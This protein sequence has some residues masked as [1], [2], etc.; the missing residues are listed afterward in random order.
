[1]QILSE[2]TPAHP[3]SNAI[4]GMTL[5][6]STRW[7]STRRSR[8]DGWLDATVES[9]GGV[10]L[11]ARIRALD[12]LGGAVFDLV[13]DADGGVPNPVL[14]QCVRTGSVTIPRTPH[15]LTTTKDG[16]TDSRTVLALRDLEIVVVLPGV[17]GR[18]P[19]ARRICRAAGQIRRG[20][21][22][23][24][25]LRRLSTAGTRPSPVWAGSPCKEPWP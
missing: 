12:L 18:R 22:R 11:A 4:V 23:D 6:L 3:S 17:V 16:S 21:R 10:P 20:A 14:L 13:T 25:L 15:V 2:G 24:F 8:W 1:M 19:G 7:I 5:T 9:S